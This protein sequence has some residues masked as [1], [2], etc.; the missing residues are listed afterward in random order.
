MNVEIGT[1]TPLF[2]FWEYLFQIFSFKVLIF[3]ILSLQCVKVMNCGSHCGMGLGKED[4]TAYDLCLLILLGHEA[5][6][7]VWR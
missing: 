4:L 7:L 5:S 3:G 2:L 1:D 6:Y